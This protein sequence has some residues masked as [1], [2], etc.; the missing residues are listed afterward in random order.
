MG[1]LR[2]VLIHGLLQLRRAQEELK[3]CQRRLSQ[4]LVTADDNSDKKLRKRGT[5]SDVLKLQVK[6]LRN[7]ITCSVCHVCLRG[8]VRSD[9]FVGNV[10]AL[11]RSGSVEGLCDQQVLPHILPPVHRRARAYSATEVPRVRGKV[12][13]R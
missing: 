7:R 11:V 1:G 6:E 13:R 4:A 8:V 2:R 10:A 5:P 12:R 9:A 3:A